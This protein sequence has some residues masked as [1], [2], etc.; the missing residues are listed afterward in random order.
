MGCMP[1][2]YFCNAKSWN[3]KNNCD[4]KGGTWPWTMCP[5]TLKN[6]S[7]PLVKSFGTKQ[8]RKSSYTILKGPLEERPGELT[9]AEANA[10]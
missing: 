7:K 9:K 10:S 3:V 8:P 2:N 4:I 1:P 5:H 6:G